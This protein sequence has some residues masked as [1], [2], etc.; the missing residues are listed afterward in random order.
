M[1]NQ[2]IDYL[3]IGHITLDKTMDGFHLGGTATYSGLT[4]AALGYRV[5]LVSV[6]G[7][8]IELDM[9]S[10]LD[11]QLKTVDRSTT[12]ENITGP[13]GR[14]QILH[15]TAEMITRDQIPPSWMTAPIV[16]LG[17]V[18]NEINPEVINLFNDNWLGITPQGWM[19]AA[20]KH[21]EVGYSPWNDHQ[22]YLERAT[23]SVLSIEDVV[24]D[25]DVIQSYSQSG[26]VVVVT[27]GFQGAR[28]Y[29]RGDVRRFKAQKIEEVDATGAGD[30]FATCF[31]HRYQQ[32]KDPWTAA[33]FAV[34]LSTV[35]VT[36][37]GLDSIPRPEEI[38]SALVEVL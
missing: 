4:A 7:N 21:H 17:P 37:N 36:R 14:I 11:L 25:E 10:D 19:R 38:R 8:E 24:Y 22:K 20:N 5:G 28:V 27:E 1:K 3:L 33:K 18:A 6:F 9:L 31:F 23:A 2:P 15:H 12:F 30:I 29:W 32:T 35:S 13:Q 34:K 16:H 26:N